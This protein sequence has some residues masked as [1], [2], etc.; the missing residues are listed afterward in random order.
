MTWPKGLDHDLD[1][2][3]RLKFSTS[4]RSP[5][6]RRLA[7]A[8]PVLVSPASP[9]P[10]LPRPLFPYLFP[11]SPTPLA[12]LSL[13]LNSQDCVLVILSSLSYISCPFSHPLSYLFS[14]SIHSRFF[15]CHLP[16][17]HH[18]SDPPTHNDNN[19]P[20]PESARAAQLGELSFSAAD[21]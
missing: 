10:S 4:P 2:L 9:F 8:L 1:S 18:I 5:V 11:S 19:E 21:T 12:F 17:D 7:V 3:H 6:G 15:L 14:S 13:L 16:L 20:T